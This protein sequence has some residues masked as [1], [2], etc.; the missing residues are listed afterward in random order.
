M[1]VSIITICYNS[2][3]T[4]ED[5]IHSVLSQDYPSIE[6]IVVD[7]ASKDNTVNIIERYRNKIGAFISEPDKGIY[8]AMNKGVAMATGDVVGILNSDDVFQNTHV[9]S[10]VV[11]A[12]NKEQTDAL[13]GDLV[14][15]KRDNPDKVVRYWKSGSYKQNS[16]VNGWMPPHPAFFL[17]KA[18]YDR[19]GVFNTELKTSADYELML[20]MLH[21]EKVS[22]AYLPQIITRMRMGGVSNASVKNRRRANQEDRLAWTLNGLNP[23][24]FTFIRKPLSKVSQFIKKGAT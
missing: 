8:Y 4:V 10:N 11:E 12:F 18:V 1:K 22:V 2:E 13:Y 3:D 15:V 6:Y 19:F 14:Y 23:G 17:R 16:F 21:K 7:G 9:I 20:R 5:T 24:T